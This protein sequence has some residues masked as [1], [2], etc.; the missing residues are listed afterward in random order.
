ME[1]VGIVETE[2]MELLNVGH[3]K[4]ARWLDLS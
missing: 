2:T 4:W 1:Q 3:V